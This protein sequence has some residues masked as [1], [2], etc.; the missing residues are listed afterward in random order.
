MCNKW[1]MSVRCDVTEFVR[2]IVASLKV[3]RRCFSGPSNGNTTCVTEYSSRKIAVYFTRSLVIT[4]IVS[5]WMTYAETY[6]DIT[7]APNVLLLNIFYYFKQGIFVWM[8]HILRFINP[9]FP[10][11]KRIENWTPLQLL[12]WNKISRFA[13]YSITISFGRVWFYA[14]PTSVTQKQCATRN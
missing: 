2:I 1:I 14:T 9:L 12:F 3:L 8:R 13:S 11:K 5:S 6:W 7:R 4:S 10:F